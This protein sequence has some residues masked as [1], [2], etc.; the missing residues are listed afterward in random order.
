M[1]NQT[2]TYRKKTVGAALAAVLLVGGAT[3]CESGKKD[4][5][6]KA[7]APA[8][9]AQP[10]S[11]AA[12]GNATEALTAAYKKTSA[13]KSAKV[14]MTMSMPASL[15][16][17]AGGTIEMTGVQ[18]W[19]PTV[20]DITMKGGALSGAG[21]ESMR[22]IMANDVMFME[23]PADSPLSAGTEGKRWM[24]LDL[25]AAAQASG[26]AEA[27]KKL[28]GMGGMD[29][30][31]DPAKQLALLLASPNVKHVGAEKVEGTD[32]EH[33]KGTLSFE[34]MLAANQKAE[35]LTAQERAKLVDAMKKAGIKGYDMDVWVNKDGYPVRMKVAMGMPQGAVNVDASYSDYGSAA[36]V[37]AP[38]ASETFD[39]FGMLKE[40]GGE[41]GAGA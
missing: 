20:M 26:D 23:M 40:L 39:L 14:R 15:G 41:P 12:G 32:A 29:Q 9:S 22:M 34:E 10:S 31:Q 25:A 5:A 38:P 1:S 21:A 8:A 11:P 33:Y 13:A 4:D 2:K 3:A 36:T 27:M 19:D 18:G 6:G 16:A 30:S 24:K 7:A 28:S 37:Q 35:A 17:G